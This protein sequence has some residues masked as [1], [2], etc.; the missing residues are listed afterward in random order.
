MALKLGMHT[1]QQDCSYEELRRLWRLADNSGF[2]WISIWDHHFESP[3]V[4]GKHAAFE[5]ISIMTALALE[6]TNVR[7][8]CLVFSPAYRN[9]GLIAKAATTIDHLSNGRV[10][11]GLGAGW[12]QPEYDAFGYNFHRAGVRE[13]MLEETAQIVRTML[14]EGVVTFEGKHFQMKDAYC[15][16]AP[17]QK[18]LPIWIG[19]AGEKRTIPAAAKY[20][21]AWNGAYVAP[22]VYRHKLAVVDQACEAIGRDPATIAR[23]VNLGFYMGIDTADAERKRGK[24]PWGPD[25]PRY[26]GQ[27]LGTASEVVDRLGEY[28]DAGAEHIN[29]AI[30][31]PFDW[32][33]L[34]AFIEEVM[35]AFS[36]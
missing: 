11:I 2:Y 29:L 16:P 23:A 36:R 24:L 13:D 26:G 20:A 30:R 21:D 12:H 31:A 28:V 5:T 27:L 14:R 33:S 1:G 3:P 8:G 34:Q 10:E 9:P 22:D 18:E 32:E 6:T 17:L 25:D 7:V 19:G 35:P 4:D 15:V